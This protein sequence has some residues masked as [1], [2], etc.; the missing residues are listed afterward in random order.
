[1]RLG[2]KQKQVRGFFLSEGF[3]VALF[4]GI[5][6]LVVSV[7][8]TLLVFK[9]LNTLWF[10]IV[11]TDVLLIK[12]NPATLIFGLII[13]V[14]I[15]L[16]AIFISVRRFQ[17]QRTADVQKQTVSV[18]KKG[19]RLLLNGVMYLSLLSSIGIFIYQ[20]ASKTQLNPTLFFL[21]GV[22]LLLGLLLLF[23]KNIY[24]VESK[25]QEDFS[26]ERL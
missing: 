9:I 4:G 7:F 21:S 6:G 26:L 23:R 8:Y 18:E 16:I 17:K 20:M 11:R 12:I 24:R 1:M 3:V 14:L 15:S 22:L 19:K 2:F 13:S 25:K 5:I 10:E